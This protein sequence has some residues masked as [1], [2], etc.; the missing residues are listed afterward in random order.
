MYRSLL[1]K[2]TSSFACF[3][4]SIMIF[5]FNRLIVMTFFYSIGKQKSSDASPYFHLWICTMEIG[6]REIVALFLAVLCQN[7][8]GEKV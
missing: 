1:R 2:K 4:S 7:D 5:L 3:L 6:S 8:V